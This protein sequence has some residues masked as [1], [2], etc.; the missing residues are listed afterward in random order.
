[1]NES[2]LL[3]KIRASVIDDHHV[4]HGLYGPR[5]I[6]YA[7]YT[8]SGRAL[9][10]IEDFI[11]DEVLPSASRSSMGRSPQTPR[12]GCASRNVR[13]ARRRSRIARSDNP[14]STSCP[15]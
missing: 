2:P 15:R 4:V 12:S 10:S 11:R 7:D 3:A 1:M 6:T 5:R 9:T 8:T 14:D 13:A